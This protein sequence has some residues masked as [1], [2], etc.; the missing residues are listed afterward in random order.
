MPAKLLFTCDACSVVL[1][2]QDISSNV[3]RQYAR[4][5]Q[6]LGK[7]HYVTITISEMLPGENKEDEEPWHEAIQKEEPET[8]TILTKAEYDGE[9]RNFFLC[10]SCA[11]KVISALE[12]GIRGGFL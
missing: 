4:F 3:D 5:D 7:T 6:A 10:A 8:A 11:R 2:H 12:A 1:G 9:G